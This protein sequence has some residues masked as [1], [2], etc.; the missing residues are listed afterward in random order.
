MTKFA[1]DLSDAEFEVKVLETNNTVLVDFWAPWCGPCQAIGPFIE[2]IA[3]E[4]EGEIQVYKVNVD[5]NKQFSS[6]LG[7][8]SIPML[9]LFHKGEIVEEIVGAPNPQYLVD[10]LEKTL[11]TE[12]S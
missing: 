6:R 11:A 10:L 12:S 4:F 7:V 5:E 1:Q 8:R 3:R 9:I 2:K